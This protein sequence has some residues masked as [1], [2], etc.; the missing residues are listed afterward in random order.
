MSGGIVPDR[1]EFCVIAADKLLCPRK[2]LGAVIRQFSGEDRF[3]YMLEH[4]AYL[5]TGMHSESDKVA[6]V[7]LKSASLGAVSPFDYL[8]GNAVEDLT[9]AL[10]VTVS[11]RLSK[12]VRHL[13]LEQQKEHIPPEL[14]QC[15]THRALGLLYLSVVPADEQQHL[16]HRFTVKSETVHYPA[17][18]LGASLRMTAKMSLTVCAELVAARLSDVMKQCGQPQHRHLARAAN[19]MERVFVDIVYVVDIPLIKADHRQQLG[20]YHS[21]YRYILAQHTYRIASAY[22]T[23]QLLAAALGAYPV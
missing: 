2:K 18:Y 22:Q 20:H 9:A 16:P 4:R 21:E 10:S 17:R 6:T 11:G 1:I 13:Q 23:Q 14:I 3:K 12:V 8:L 15:P 19:Y 7:Y 5:G